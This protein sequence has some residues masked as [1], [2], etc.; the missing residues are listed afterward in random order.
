MERRK[1]HCRQ[2]L[3]IL[4]V[5]RYAVRLAS[6]NHWISA[7]KIE[8]LERDIFVFINGISVHGPEHPIVSNYHKRT[9]YLASPVHFAHREA[10]RQRGWAFNPASLD[11]SIIADGSTS[12][13][14]QG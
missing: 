2:A 11:F 8:E 6:I 12:A 13:R 3:T 10:S 4:L 5:T 7:D 14:N 1:L 9:R